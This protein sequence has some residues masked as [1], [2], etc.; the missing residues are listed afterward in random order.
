MTMAFTQTKRIYLASS[1]L[2]MGSVV[3]ILFRPTS[4]LMFNWADALGLMVPIHTLRMYCL[5]GTN[6]LP[7]WFIYSFPFPLWVVAYLLFVKAVWWRSASSWR[8]LWFWC[9]PL[10]SVIAEICQYFGL[11]PGTFDPVD[12]LIIILCVAFP[13]SMHTLYATNLIRRVK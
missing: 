4:L 2:L 3:Y 13:L 7:S 5:S 8:Y 6:F 10:I 9:V 12:L 11:I 1:F